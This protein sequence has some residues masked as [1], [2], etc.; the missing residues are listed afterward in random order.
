M[1]KPT[2]QTFWTAL[3]L[4]ILI[5]SGCASDPLVTGKPQDWVG[6]PA[7]DLKKFMGEPQQ[8]ITSANGAEVWTY[9]SAE[10]R[11]IP[12]GESMS[13]FGG[14]NTERAAG[15]FSSEKRPED[16]MTK[17]EHLYR[18]K[19][20]GGIVTEWYAARIVDGRTVWEDH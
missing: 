19:V 16:R 8:S 4:S 5:F 3:V 1:N 2:F 17:I 7:V 14:A 11:I 20:K 13:F 6:K 10:D 18:F 15:A 9:R 12:K